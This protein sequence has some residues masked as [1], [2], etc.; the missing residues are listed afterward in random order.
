[1]EMM[2]RT[3]YEELRAAE[4]PEAQA[5]SVARHLPDWSQFATKADLKEL[6]QDMVHLEGRVE[7]QLSQLE[8][9]LIRWMVGIL[10]VILA[11]VLTLGSMLMLALNSLF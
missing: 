6:R 3:A 5:T 7:Q 9:R 11:A 2:N 8:S 4:M 10:V 1:M